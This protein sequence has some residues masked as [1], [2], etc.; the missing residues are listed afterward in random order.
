M[1]IGSVQ[2]GYLNGT[3][4]EF[5][6]HG[7][8][9]NGCVQCHMETIT[10]PEPKLS[11]H[12]FQMRLGGCVASDC[13]TS[14]NVAAAFMTALQLDTT[15]RIQ[16]VVDLLNQWG[17]NKAPAVLRTN[18]GRYSWEYTTAGRLSN[19]TGTNTVP[20]TTNVIAGP[21]SSGQSAVPDQIKKARLNAY[22]VELDDSKGVHNKTYT[23]FL[24]NDA[25]TNVQLLLRP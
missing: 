19:P 3:V 1:L 22:L 24:L 20:G 25:K 14:T 16:Q 10:G 21:S 9:T 23:R 6:P 5:G 7:L 11:G 17:T 4:N 12:S 2:P 13:H 15:A 18:Y 8:I